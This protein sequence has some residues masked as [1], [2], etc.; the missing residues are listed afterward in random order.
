MGKIYL[1]RISGEKMCNELT[2]RQTEVLSLLSKGLTNQEICKA[3]CISSNTVKV[4]LANIYKILEVTNRTEAVSVLSMT[5]SSSKMEVQLFFGDLEQIESHNDAKYF[6]LSLI[7]KLHQFELLNIQMVPFDF[8]NKSSDFWVKA[9]FSDGDYSSLF[10]SLHHVKTPEILWTTSYSF[11]KKNDLEQD[12]SRLCIQLWSQIEL[13]SARLYKRDSSLEPQWWYLTSYHHIKSDARTKESWIDAEKAILALPEKE[14]NHFYVSSILASM[15]YKAV[16][17]HWCYHEEYES[18][19]R[20]LA[21]YAM[22]FNS[23]S[24]YSMLIIAFANILTGNQDQS[25]FYLEKILAVNPLNIRA[26]Q[27]LAQIYMLQDKVEQGLQELT[28][29]DKMNPNLIEKPYILAI[30]ALMLCLTQR[31]TEC[32][33]FCSEILFI[34]PETPIPRLMLISAL[35]W[36]NR[37]DEAKKHIA[38]FNKYHSDFKLE[39]WDSLIQGIHSEKKALLLKGLSLAKMEI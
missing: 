16:L 27:L 34:M 18:L 35:G 10:L 22:R 11:S 29:Y 30:R 15:R 19:I 13:A 4:H 7:K 23:Q 12:S 17:E 20:G 3:L 26:R 9:Y 2:Q 38:L 39:N 1:W 14:K 24:Q 37:L 6:Y 25:A 31:F 33:L 36:E 28:Y 21:T 5:K 32:I 8:Q